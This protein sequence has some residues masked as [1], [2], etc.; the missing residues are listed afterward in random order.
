[1]GAA[2]HI[3]FASASDLIHWDNPIAANRFAR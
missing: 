3:E 2:R 1:L